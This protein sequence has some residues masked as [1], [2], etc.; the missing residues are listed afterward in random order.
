M[1]K[2]GQLKE[3]FNKHR[4]RSEA[5]SEAKRNAEKNQQIYQAL[6]EERRARQTLEA[7]LAQKN[8]DLELAIRDRTKELEDSNKQLSEQ[9]ALRLSL[10]H[11]SSP[12]DQRGSRMP[13][14]A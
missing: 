7:E 13:S 1:N 9:I 12:R 14:S 10:I 4:A 5:A 2:F 11:I 8:T 6:I 3:L